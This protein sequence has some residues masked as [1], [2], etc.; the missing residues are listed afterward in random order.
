[1]YKA[2]KEIG[3]YEIGDEVPI[4]KALVWLKMYSVPHV[5]KVGGESDKPSE[6]KKEEKKLE[7]S[8][9]SGNPMLED[10]LGRNTNVVKKNVEDDDL[11]QE[12]IAELLELEKSN[13]KRDVVIKALETKL[14]KF[15]A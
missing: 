11:S 14:K 12:Q 3:G 10:Y 8:E 2:I 9:T 15:G 6:D 7:T 4:E 1:M 13:K 5:E